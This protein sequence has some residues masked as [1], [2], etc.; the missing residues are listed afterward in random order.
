MKYDGSEHRRPGRPNNPDELRELVARMAQENPGWGYR[1][2]VMHSGISDMRFV[3]ALETRHVEVAGIIRQPHG[4]WMLQVTMDLHDIVDA[5]LTGK[6]F[7]L[8]E[9]TISEWARR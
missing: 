5:F 8:L 6:R 7:L 4:A 1:E 3:I 2:S 9:L